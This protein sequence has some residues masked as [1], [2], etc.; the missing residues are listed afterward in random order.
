MGGAVKPLLEVEGRRIV[1]RQ[2]D[3]LAPRVDE[4]VISL[5]APAGDGAA[6]PGRVVIDE[7][8]DAGPLAGIAAVLGAA[9]TPWVLVVA[10]DMAWLDGVV[11]DALIVRRA[12]AGRFVVPRIGGYP[13]PL[14]AMYHRSAI[15]VIAP[16]L[17]RGERSAS[18]L[19]A[20]DGLD[21]RWVEEVALRAIDPAL[22]SF[23]GVNRPADLA[24]A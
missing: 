8:R 18:R 24:G 21:V 10:G 22:R 5:A 9:T 20:A 19:L 12:T 4:I 7:V 15:Q 23:A 13:E 14:L 1:D 17:A 2:V 11:I 6:W 3:V 16:A